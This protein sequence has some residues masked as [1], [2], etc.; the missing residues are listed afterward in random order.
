MNLPRTGMSAEHFAECRERAEKM[1]MAE[2]RHSKHDALEAARALD[3]TQFD[4]NGA[5]K[6]AGFYWDEY[7]T[8]LDEI[9]RRNKS[10]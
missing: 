10:A 5:C 4:N 7:C 8:L 2:L 9:Y 6:G 1:T 3:K